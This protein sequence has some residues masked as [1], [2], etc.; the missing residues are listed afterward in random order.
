[1]RRYPTVRSTE[2]GCL[3]QRNLKLRFTVSRH[4]A[5]PL[6]HDVFNALGIIIFRKLRV[7]IF[8]EPC[9]V[10][11]YLLASVT[12]GG[13]RSVAILRL[14]G[15]NKAARY[16]CEPVTASFFRGDWD[17]YG[18]ALRC[19][20]G[21]RGCAHR[22]PDAR[23]ERCIGLT[24]AGRPGRCLGQRAPPWSGRRRDRLGGSTRRQPG[25]RWHAGRRWRSRTPDVDR[26]Q[27]AFR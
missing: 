20:R 9:C 19:L 15:D 12:A 16:A 24:L 4:V 27:S 10:H 23:A 25:R 2:I 8:V 21:C 5:I 18:S 22:G 1:M 14:Q 11:V 6:L 26:S 3:A 7:K 17:D 13:D